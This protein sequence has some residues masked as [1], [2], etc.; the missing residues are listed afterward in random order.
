MPEAVASNSISAP[1]GQPTSTVDLSALHNTIREAE[2]LTMMLGAL[3]DQES[4]LHRDVSFGLCNLLRGVVDNFR[5]IYDDAS[6]D[7]PS[8]EIRGT[9][10]YAVLG[11]KLRSRLQGMTADIWRECN[12]GGDETSVHNIGFV[13]KIAQHYTAV[14]LDQLDDK[15][16]ALEAGSF[17]PWAEVKIRAEMAKDAG[18]AFSDVDYAKSLLTDDARN[19]IERAAS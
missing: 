3:L 13:S 10:I 1:I 17:L 9:P 18:I 7:A 6:K 8:D 16:D 4:N 12:P 11:N 2:A 14:I 5:R 15:N 19:K